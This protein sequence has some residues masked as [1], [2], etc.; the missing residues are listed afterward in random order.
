MSSSASLLS[1]CSWSHGRNTYNDA[2]TAR[3]PRQTKQPTPPNSPASPTCVQ[4]HR[5]LR[6]SG[7][8]DRLL[9]T[10]EQAQR[11]HLRTR[12]HRGRGAGAEGDPGRSRR[13]SRKPDLRSEGPRG[14]GPQAEL[15]LRSARTQTTANRRCLAAGQPAIRR[16]RETG[17]TQPVTSDDRQSLG[18][19]FRYRCVFRS[20]VSVVCWVRSTITR[21]ARTVGDRA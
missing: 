3:T 5:R 10:A 7:R 6:G 19:V 9:L 12:L 15:H 4:C 17:P 14:R 8:L 13:P 1:E 21:R 20:A 16:A 11:D 2:K 18:S